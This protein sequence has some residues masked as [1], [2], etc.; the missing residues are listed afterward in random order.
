[1]AFFIVKEISK[2][3]RL[4]NFSTKKTTKQLFLDSFSHDMN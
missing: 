2:I 4:L 1:M 3:N